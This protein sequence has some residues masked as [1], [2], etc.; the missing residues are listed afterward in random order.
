[1]EKQQLKAVFYMLIKKF[2]KKFK[3]DSE[4]NDATTSLLKRKAEEVTC[5]K[6]EEDKL[7]K[8]PKLD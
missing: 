4:V 3:K 1:M 6:S 8:I 7:R 5:D 2:L